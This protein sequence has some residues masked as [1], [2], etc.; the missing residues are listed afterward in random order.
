[1][2]FTQDA[3]RPAGTARMRPCRLAACALLLAGFAP[4][5]TPAAE[6]EAAAV[7]LAALLAEAAIHNPELAAARQR[8]AAAQARIAPA[9]ALDD[10][11]LEAGIL[12]APLAP[13]SLR[14]EDMTMQMLGVSQ[15]FPFPG[16]RGLRTATAE[17]EAAA[18]AAYADDTCDRVM[19]DLRLGYEELAVVMAE[20]DIVDAT[21][22][23]LEEYVAI[24]EARYAVGSAPQ[25]DVLQA[26]AQ[27]AQTRAQLLDLDR[28]RLESQALLAQLTGRDAAAPV[29][30]ATAQS[31]GPPPVALA[32]LADAATARPRQLALAEESRQAR[33]SIAL[34]RREYYPDIDLRLQYGRRERALD[35]LPRDDMISLTFAV[36]LPIWRRQRLEPQVAEARATLAEREAM[37]RAFALETKTQLARRHAAATQARRTVEIYDTVILPTSTAALNAALASYRVGQI[38]FLTLLATR[39][40]LYEVRMARVAAVAEHNRASAEI[41]YLAGRRLVA[42]G[43]SP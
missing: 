34:A 6:S 36:N 5:V 20:R 16:K 21:R 28:R 3:P 25:T 41:D 2:W 40:R 35:G 29:I 26:E 7:P 38:D 4:L 39:M 14:R 12:S 32:V 19:R 10:P 27:L 15:R 1:M 8:A 33:E 24:A 37:E 22:A 31:L 17:A 9:G 42:M 13:L 23:A 43:K 18:S 30:V 11:M